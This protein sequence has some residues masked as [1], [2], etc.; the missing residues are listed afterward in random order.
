MSLVKK[1]I[2]NNVTYFFSYARLI[3]AWPPQ[4]IAVNQFTTLTKKLAFERPYVP[5]TLNLASIHGNPY[6]ALGKEWSVTSKQTTKEKLDGE[7]R[8]NFTTPTFKRPE[9]VTI[10]PN[11]EGMDV[12]E[13]LIATSSQAPTIRKHLPKP[14]KL[15]NQV[16]KPQVQRLKQTVSAKNAFDIKFL[17]VQELSRKL[18]D[19]ARYIIEQI[20]FIPGK[21]LIDFATVEHQPIQTT[22][23]IR[24]KS[25]WD[26][27]K[28]FSRMSVP[29]SSGVK[30]P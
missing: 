4:Q 18:Q 22:S 15:I 25:G 13:K 2:Q 19:K 30:K 6:T 7:N 12:P 14:V 21:H 10:T 8:T 29:D 24:L 1:I 9:D 11:S 27:N 17:K 23:A 20:M 28:Q 5:L 26:K 3:T 16:M